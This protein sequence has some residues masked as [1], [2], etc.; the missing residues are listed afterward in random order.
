MVDDAALPTLIVVSGPPGSGK[1]TLAHEIARAAGCPAVSRDEIKEGMAHAA[2]GFTPG[3]GDE[4][5]MR[6]LPV[7]FAVLRLLLE[8]GVTTVA[9]AAFQDRVWRPRLEPLLPVAL[10]RVVH[11]TTD[12]EVAFT[13]IIGRRGRDGTRRAHPD[14]GPADREAYVRRLRAFSRLRLDVPSI[15]VDTTS[16]YRPSLAEVTAFAAGQVT[17]LALSR[18]AVKST[19]WPRSRVRSRQGRSSRSANIRSRTA[20]ETRARVSAARPS[21]RHPRGDHLPAVAAAHVGA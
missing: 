17:G 20:S 14:P 4:L 12:P 8:A 6:T 7:F 9:E 15:E 5:T 2:P 10:L 18:P 21:S 13:R 1:T 3:E 19:G 11:C 16:G